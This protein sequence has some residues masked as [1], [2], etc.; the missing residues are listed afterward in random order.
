MSE[1]E[2]KKKKKEKKDDL[3]DHKKVAMDHLIDKKDKDI[4][5]QVALDHIKDMKKSIED[6]V[7]LLKAEIEKLKATPIPE[8]AAVPNGIT[9]L[10]KSEEAPTELSKAEVIEELISLKKSNPDSVSSRDITAV[11]LGQANPLEVLKKYKKG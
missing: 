4:H 9:P 3:E 8:K 1:K 5:K 2:K 11:E 6:E 10:K 7:S